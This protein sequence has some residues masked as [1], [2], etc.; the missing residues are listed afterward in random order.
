MMSI[1]IKGWLVKILLVILAFY[2][3]GNEYVQLRNETSWVKYFASFW[4]YIDLSP[5][6]LV[7]T[8]I[9]MSLF[10]DYDKGMVTQWERYLNAIASFFIWFKFLYFFRIFRSFGHLI[11][12]IIGVL[13]DLKVFMVILTLSIL[14]FSGTFFILAQNNKTEN[15]KLDTFPKAVIQMYELMLGSFDTKEYGNSGYALTYFM[16][17]L[18][19]MFLIVIMLNLL[20]AI[21]SDTFANVQGQAKRKMYQEF[22]QLI[23][24]SYHLLT[25]SEKQEF[26]SRG[27]YLFCSHIQQGSQLNE[28]TSVE[29]EICTHN[30]SAP[31]SGSELEGLTNEQMKVIEVLIEKRIQQ[32]MTSKKED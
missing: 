5:N 4:N 29:G 28:A 16:F 19:S 6:I 24:E 12:A 2:F 9:T 23:C 32:M 18:A 15:M 1:K 27:N 21:I 10:T 31:A 17:A 20:I 26:D 30:H 25:E 8:A 13:I 14:A 7:I 3:L 22:A 11:S